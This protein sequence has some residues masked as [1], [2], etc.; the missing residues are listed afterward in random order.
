MATVKTILPP[1]QIRTLLRI[2]PYC[3]VSSGSDDQ[4]HSFAAQVQ[5]YTELVQ[6]HPEWELVD[7]YADEGITG[8]STERREEFQRLMQD[9]AR[10]KIDRIITKSVS[11]FAR[12]TVDCL[13]A[14][15][16]LSAMGVS[17][18]FEKEQIDTAKM[19]SEIM[20][21]MSG[22]QAQDESISISTNMRWSY[23]KRMKNGSF[24][25]NCAPYGYRL[26]NGELLIEPQ[27][28]EVI[29]TIFQMFLSGVSRVRIAKF[30]N[31][32]GIT[33]DGENA[34][35]ND[36]AIGYILENEKYA[37]DAL[38]QKTFTPNTLASR[39]IPNRG[40][41]KRYY[42]EYSHAPIIP[43]EDYEKAQYLLQHNNRQNRTHSRYLL[44]HLLRCSHCG[45]TY[46]RVGE[47]EGA[48]WKCGYRGAYASPCP[49]VR[50][51]EEDILMTLGRMLEILKENLDSILKPA[52]S[53]L[54]Q[55]RAKING[56]TAKV[57]EID[58]EIAVLSRKLHNIARL[59]TA[60]ILDPADFAA[61]NGIVNQQITALR[62]KRSALLNQSEDSD[63]L[64]K[65]E[66]VCDTLEIW[67]PG[68][69]LEQS[70]LCKIVDKITVL[71]KSE[72]SIQ[73]LGGLTLHEQLPEKKRRCIRT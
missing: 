73:L 18:L 44:S 28:A 55:A 5:Y 64:K 9:C 46:R 29:K 23:E 72:L 36:F 53:K 63:N 17:V 54:E 43:K 2:A 15:R 41:R 26:K 31:Q 47:G 71:S 40:E 58:C 62:R 59:Q 30:L 16:Q 52:I 69:K 32:N 33:H 34:R 35:W 70:T 42:I 7:I 20:L 14:V 39:S 11:R 50:I 57:Y 8:T 61:Q 10:G 12:N 56:T 51:D 66:E 48:Y 49:P 13:S 27:E 60:G 38:L 45:Y 65:L 3:R 21:A 37:G 19:S 22:I 67:E 68:E 6:K 25:T 24:I 1:E 4:Q